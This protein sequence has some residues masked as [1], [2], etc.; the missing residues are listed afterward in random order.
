MLT[1]HIHAPL[2]NLHTQVQGTN[3]VTE[4]D[5]CQA[6]INGEAAMIKRKAQEMLDEM[7]RNF[8]RLPLGEVIRG[9]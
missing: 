7:M 6:V 3:S 5:L 4:E 8:D 9:S 2:T 1:L